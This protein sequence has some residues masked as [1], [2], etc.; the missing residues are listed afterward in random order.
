MILNSKLSTF[1]R[2]NLFIGLAPR[3]NTK[4]LQFVI[5]FC[6]CS[7]VKNME[8]KILS[9]KSNFGFFHIL[10]F[11]LPVPLKAALPQI[12]YSKSFFKFV[13]GL[14]GPFGI[15]GCLVFGLFWQVKLRDSFRQQFLS[16]QG[17]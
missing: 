2:Q 11:A 7:N 1:L 5:F 8:L 16:G 10:D 15:A 17:K 6:C 14:I 9:R 12:I 3:S 13:F 4:K